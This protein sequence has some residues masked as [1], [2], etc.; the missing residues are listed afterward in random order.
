MPFASTRASI[1]LLLPLSL[2][3][4][5]GDSDGSRIYLSTT[6]ISI[7]AT[8]GEE[9]PPRN[10]DVHVDGGGSFSLHPTWTTATIAGVQLLGSGTADGALQIYFRTPGALANGTYHDTVD[11]HACS[12]SQCTAEVAGSPARIQVT[13]VVSGE[14]TGAATIDRDSIQVSRDRRDHLIRE[15]VVYVAV[16]PLPDTGFAVLAT[17]TENGI[18]HVNA[19][20]TSPTTAEIG[21][22]FTEG[23]QMPTGT[24]EDTVTIS[25]CYDI[26]CARHLRGSPFTVSVATTVRTGLEPG[27]VP[28]EVASRVAL[29][30]DVIDAEFSRSLG[31]VVMV[32]REPAHALYAYDIASGAEHTVPLAW[33]ATSL[34][35]SPDGRRA[36]VGHNHRIT[37]V[38][39]STLGQPAAPAPVVLTVGDYVWDVMIDD[40]GFVH[41]TPGIHDWPRSVDVATNT[42]R[43]GSERMATGAPARLHPDGTAFY[44][45][46][47]L[48]QVASLQRWDV[49]SGAAVLVHES[50]PGVDLQTCGEL[51]FGESGS[52]IYTAC[53]NVF[54]ARANPAKDMVPIG[55]IPLSTSDAVFAATFSIKSLTETQ[56]RGEVALVEDTANYCR[57]DFNS[58]P[59]YTH[60]TT[61]ESR[62]LALK[63]V[64]AIGPVNV[65][66]TDY[67]Q[68]GLFVFDSAGGNA[69]IL[70]SRLENMRDPAAEFYLSMIE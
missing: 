60:L 9:V 47:P 33:P 65:S 4:C 32:A 25:A 2:V 56:S 61:Y 23:T 14:G 39:L 10:V 54:R 41:A 11:I 3:A 48:G 38:D 37:V 46:T 64:R 7:A 53:G 34:A 19:V 12:D 18:F 55:T 66:G 24:F 35:V 22:L 57:G 16:E 13:Y 17:S 70:I 42:E 68:V 67:A 59:C 49:S 15:E 40:A 1:A 62:H 20:Q 52:S 45:P 31:Q 50:P 8:P 44:V 43:L 58:S 5:L 51:W 21:I 27:V 36:A 28:L 30:H 29:A 26:T 63:E 69:R 6:E